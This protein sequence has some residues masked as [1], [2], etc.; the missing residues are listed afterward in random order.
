MSTQ[1]DEAADEL[2]TDA[3]LENQAPE[4]TEPSAAS[5]DEGGDLP[6]AHGE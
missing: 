1:V 5:D 3:T 4:L 2:L 6:I